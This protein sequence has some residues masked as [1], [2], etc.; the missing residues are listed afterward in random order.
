MATSERRDRFDQ[1][2]IKTSGF[3][4]QL[5]SPINFGRCMRNLLSIFLL[6][7]GFNA[8]AQSPGFTDV[9][10]EFRRVGE[11][12]WRDAGKKIDVFEAL[13]A[14]SQLL[15]DPAYGGN[16]SLNDKVELQEWEFQKTFTINTKKDAG[17][18]ILTGVDTYAD[19]YINDQQVLQ[20][21]NA[22]LQYRINISKWIEKGENRLRIVFHSPIN[23]DL[24]QAISSGYLYPA[25]SDRHPKKTSVF[26]RKPAYHFGWDFAPR[27]VNYSVQD[28]RI[29]PERSFRI[30]GFTHRFINQAKSTTLMVEAEIYSTSNQ[31]I[32]VSIKFDST[33][34][35]KT[36]AL[37]TGLNSVVFE[38]PVIE[39]QYWWPNGMGDPFLYKLEVRCKKS[40]SEEIQS[41]RVGIS[42]IKLEQQADA[43]GESFQF[44][45]NRQPFF[46][47][48]FNYI[49]TEKSITEAEVK[50]WAESGVNMIRVWG[51]G[52]YG[53]DELYK[54][55]DKYGI[56]IWQDFM[57][58][59]TM[60]PGDPVFLQHVKEEATYQIKRLRDHPCL[61][62]WCGN[63]EIAVAWKNWGWQEKYKYS[64]EDSTKLIA[65]Y[66]SLFNSL[67]PQLVGEFDPGR[68]YIPS[69]PISNW[70]KAEDFTIGDNHFWGVYH[71]EM[72]IEAYND[73]VPRFA[74]EY[75]MQSYPPLENLKEFI[76]DS[77]LKLTNPDVIR[78]Q[79]SYKGNALLDRYQEMYT[80]K[81]IDL[82]DFIYKSQ[83]I[84]SEAMKTA[85]AAHRRNMNTCAGSLL[86]QWN[87]V[88][89][90]ASW[91]MVDNTSR[92]KAP[93]YEVLNS[94]K[95]WATST[96][97]KDDKLEVWLM[98]DGMEALAVTVNL[99]LHSFRG[100][101][102]QSINFNVDNVVNES[103]LIH[104]SPLSR[105]IA[106]TNKQTLWL[107]STV[108]LKGVIVA[109]NVMYFDTLKNLLIP[110][111]VIHA[112]PVKG[113]IRLDWQGEL[114]YLHFSVA[115]E[116]YFAKPGEH[117]LFL[118]FDHKLLPRIKARCI[119]YPELRIVQ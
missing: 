91:S 115:G 39:P 90:S 67:L 27:R 45:A 26:T 81:A 92:K 87:D 22:F 106:N 60:Y 18:L 63:N 11:S 55:C 48:G 51:G 79:R 8:V 24:S 10:W 28:I 99:T 46:A 100:D 119:N 93:Y 52:N 105:W 70:G 83:V 12:E 20:T 66:D 58:A 38:V 61:A 113:G 3:T 56:V 53:D 13:H 112:Q 75:G 25:D 1:T 86:W 23:R 42:T 33:V 47:K 116:G 44:T 21:G 43:T 35:S 73:H 76:A 2:K 95:P 50:T 114:P 104:S 77:L 14:N 7:F 37:K 96:L 62:M 31:T 15:K 4:F 6:L 88:A 102:L 36:Q 59:N 97:I 30:E 89:P 16:D 40:G 9:S 49:Q 118:P 41:K 85:I 84:Q 109:R 117:S 74:S 64:E 65:G 110:E 32:D 101:T 107:E 17:E 72:S 68:A 19:V 108:R 69:S 57:F 78:L 5:H 111:P 54:L 98:N 94:F 71:G 29:E 34:V 103:R 80:G 82:S